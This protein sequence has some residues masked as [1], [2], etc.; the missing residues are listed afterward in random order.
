MNIP[1]TDA[2]AEQAHA[3][4]PPTRTDDQIL[5]SS[6]WVP[7]GKS[8]CVLDVLKSQRNPIFLIVVAIL[9]NTNFFMA[10]TASS[11]IPAIYIQQFWDTM[12]FNSSTRIPKYSQERVGNVGQCSISTIE[13][14]LVHDQHVPY[15][16]WEEFVQSI[17]TFLTNRKNLATASHRKKKTTHM[18]IPSIRFTKLIIYHLK[19]K[20]SIHP[21]FGSPLHYS[22]DK[23]I[24]NT[25]RYVK[26][27]GREIF[28][29]PIPD[30]LLTDEIKGASY[31][32][33]YQEHVVKYQQ[34][35]DA[36]HGKA[37]E[38]GAIESSK[39][40]KVTTPKAAK[41]TKPASDPKPKPAP[42]QP[43]TSVPK[44]KR[45]LVRE[46]SNEPS[47]T[48]RSKDGQVRKIP[49]PMS[50]LNKPLT[51]FGAKLKEQAKRTHGPTRPV[52]IREPESRRFQP[53]PENPKNKSPVDQFI[54]QRCTLMPTEASGRAESPS[55]DAEPALPDSETESNDEVPKINTGD[56]DEGQAGPNLGIQDEGQD[57]PNP[58]TSSVP[59]MTTPVIDLTMSQSGSPLPTS[60]A[61][62]STVMTTT[63]IPPPPP[64]PHQSI[65]YPILMKRIDELKQHMAN[66]L[67]YN[68]ALRKDHK[69]LY[70]ALEKSL[71]R[72]Y[73]YQLLLDLEE[74]YQKKR[75][76]RDLPLTPP[77]A[78]VTSGS[79]QQQASLYG[80]QEL[81]STDY[82]IQYD[83]IP[84]EQTIPSSNVSDVE[85]NWATALALTYVTPTKNSL[86]AKI[87]D[88]MNFLNWYRH[89]VNKTKLT[90]ADLEGQAY[91]VVKA[92]YP[93]VI[94]LQHGSKGS[95]HALLISKMKDASYPDFGLELLVPKQMWIEDVCTYDIHAKVKE[96]KIKQLNPG[97][98]TYFWTQKD[99]TRS[100]EFIAAIESGLVFYLHSGLQT[101]PSSGLVLPVGKDHGEYILQSIGEGPFKMG[102]CKDEIAF[103]EGVP[104]ARRM[105]IPLPG[106]CTA[107]MKK[108][109]V[110]EKWHYTKKMAYVL[111][112][113]LAVTILI[114]V[115]NTN[116]LL[117]GLLRDIY[118]LINHNTDAKD[119]WDNVKM[120]LEGF[121]LTKDN[122][123]Y[124]LY[125]EFEHF[126]Q[127][128]GENI[129]DYYVKFIKLINNKRHIKMTMPKIQLN[130]KF[131]NNMLPEW[132]RFVTAVKLNRGLKESNHDQLYAY[133]KQRESHANENKMLMDILNQHSHDPL[134]LVS[135]VS[136][137][138]YPSSSFVPP[139]SS[140][141]SPVT[142]QPSFIDNTQLDTGLSRTDELLDNL[143]KQ[144]RQNIVH[145]NNAEGNVAVGNG[146]AQNRVGNANAGEGK[147]I[148]C[149]NCNGIGHIARNY[150]QPKRPHNSDYF[151]KK[152]S[153]MQ[154]QEN[155]VDLDEEQLLFLAV[156][157]TNTLYDDVDEGPVQ[158]MFMAN[159]SSVAPVYDE[160]VPSY[161]LD[162]LFEVQNHDNCLDDI[163]EYHEEHE[164]QHDVQPNNVVDSDTEYTSTSNIIDV[165]QTIIYT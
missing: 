150:N 31:Y 156:G 5:S 88:M 52:V 70:N 123:E 22:H 71:E 62:T 78:T 158:K 122:H 42:T 105:E 43:P 26:K 7:I 44:K 79:T 28:G 65:T 39:D 139:Q 119:I 110:K 124:Q 11:T 61:T 154:A 19:T 69:K 50:S 84:D 93:D 102:W 96:F 38:G 47:A 100:K 103:V 159:L 94:N 148:K 9:K 51:G 6:N 18:L 80:T 29:M 131:V 108:L 86:L 153:L 85:N 76:R 106:V 117:Q 64:Q 160:T 140:Y 77:P 56:Q 135:N 120:L 35:L 3:I 16:I 115:F 36:E 15:R 8:N 89:Q 66:L 13:S 157:Q 138:Q 12:C 10:F 113:I 127:H 37:A 2:P 24:L 67:Q 162:T 114:L 14:Y 164:M 95:N 101:F 147:P 33:E 20:H 45:K 112:M 55:L 73:S 32:G 58:D 91:E 54:F 149:Y 126:R 145:G 57:G 111:P 30:A 74:A 118:K 41:T 151:K 75:K 99:V 98:N 46:T 48:K 92:F 116:I 83:S 27:D 155:E 34:H 152:M 23:S 97:M 146:G 130:S 107:M 68:L 21:R 142:Y 134:T 161:D 25:L 82:L 163:N 125:D 129:N 72:D 63:S 40:T 144:G 81:S 109:P 121:K 53:L 141:I 165:I 4:A 90:Q 60:S 87:G 1:A 137:Y 59:P 143:T 132:G 104:T 133:L 17:Q 49:K 136:P 128:K